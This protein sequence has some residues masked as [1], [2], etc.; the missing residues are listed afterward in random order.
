MA[1]DI[2][3]M[4]ADRRLDAQ[5]GQALHTDRTSVAATRYPSA[6]QR[7]WCV[8]TDVRSAAIGNVMC[9]VC[10][11]VPAGGGRRR[12][13]RGAPR[14]TDGGGIGRLRATSSG[15]R[16]WSRATSMLCVTGPVVARVRGPVVIAGVPSARDRGPMAR[17]PRFAG[18]R[19]GT[20]ST[21]PRTGDRRPRSCIP[22]PR[23]NDPYRGT[24]EPARRHRCA[25]VHV[26]VRCGARLRVVHPSDRIRRCRRRVPRPPHQHRRLRLSSPPRS[27]PRRPTLLRRRRRRLMRRPMNRPRHRGDTQR[28]TSR[29]L[30][31]WPLQD[32]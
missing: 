12:E 23:A 16:L 30:T 7:Q 6:N 20:G 10:V 22:R 4:A 17:G 13:N 21:R 26:A 1:P 27:V 31:H 5:D 9:V 28:P 15:A 25:G 18:Q 3:T 29:R 2:R 14:S 11:R 24:C 32:L 8:I 19:Q